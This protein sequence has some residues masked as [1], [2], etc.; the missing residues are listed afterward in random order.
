MSTSKN[1]QSD[2]AGQGEIEENLPRL[3]PCLSAEQLGKLAIRDEDELSAD[4]I[5]AQFQLREGRGSIKGKSVLI[6]ISGIEL[7]GKGEA[8]QQLRE[9]VD[10]RYLMVKAEV[11]HPL[12]KSQP[13]WQPYAGF[14]PAE[15]QMKLLFGNWYSDL[16]ATAM[17]VSEPINTEQF[18]DY[19]QKN[20]KYCSHVYR[21]DAC[22][23]FFP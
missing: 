1:K 15:G 7:A 13:F 6:L 10:P 22:L 3:M 20:R 9:W 17:H 14:I 21:L 19:V 11:P 12:T 23:G 8:V 18:K 16:L 2:Q 4:L 5:E